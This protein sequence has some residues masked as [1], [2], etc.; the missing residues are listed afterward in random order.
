MRLHRATLRN[1]RIHRQLSVDFN[2]AS[3]LI[4]GPN[5]S[6]KSTL[7][8]AIHRALFLKAKGNTEAHREMVAQG[9]D[10]TPEVQLEFEAGGRRWQLS[11]SFGAAARGRVS[12]SD[13]QGT[14]LA[15]DA[16]EEFLAGL[17]GSPMAGAGK[18]MLTQWAHLWVWQGCSGDDPGQ[19]SQRQHE[20]LI[21]RLQEFGGAGLVQSDSDCRVAT[22]IA[23]RVDTI[24]NRNGT[25]KAGSELAAAERA[26]T[27]ARD[28]RDKARLRW[29]EYG[30]RADDLARRQSEK[31]QAEKDLI[32]LENQRNTVT[33]ALSK[34]EE[35]EDQLKQESIQL[36]RDESARDGLAKTLREFAE[37]QS[38][39]TQTLEGLEPIQR[40]QDQLR[41]RVAE[42]TTEHAQ[43]ESDWNAKRETARRARITLDWL[44]ARLQLARAED[45]F[46]RSQ[47]QLDRLEALERDLAA[48]RQRFAG[49]RPID[50]KGLKRLESLQQAL[51]EAHI[52]LE[53]M[54]A[55]VEWVASDLPVLV[56]GQPLVAGQ[57]RRLTQEGLLQIGTGT[58]L[59]I[60]PGGGGSV[61]EATEARD[62]AA[63]RLRAELDGRGFEDVDT[64]RAAHEEWGVASRAVQ[65]AEQAVQVLDAT[66]VRDTLEVRRSRLLEAQQ[67]VQR[68]EPLVRG[69]EMGP[70]PEGDALQGRIREAREAFTQAEQEEATA[71]AR[72]TSARRRLDQ[73]QD[74]LNTAVEE[75]QRLETARIELEAR[76]TLLRSTHG[77]P[78]DLTNQLQRATTAVEATKVRKAGIQSQV[79]QLNPSALGIRR[80][81]I[82]S[83]LGQLKDRLAT[84]W[85]AILV[86][87]TQL[88]TGMEGGEDPRAAAEQ[89]AAVLRSRE[90]HLEALRLQAEAL[91]RLRD[92]FEEEQRSMASRLVEP[93]QERIR[94]Y[95]GWI[96]G[97]GADVRV[98]LE[99]NGFGGLTLLR[100][101]GFATRFGFDSLSGGTREQVAVAFRLAMAEVLAEDHDGC[102]PIVLDDAFAYSDPDRVK[103]LQDMLFQATKQ[104]LQVIVLTCTPRDY[105]G[106]SGAEILLRRPLPAAP[107]GS[108]HRESS[109][110]LEPREPGD[111]GD[112]VEEGFDAGELA[113]ATGSGAG[114]VQVLPEWCGA[115]LAALP[116][117]GG[118][119]GNGTLQREL[120][121]DDVRYAA[122]RDH[123]LSEAR[124]E[125]GRG[126]GGSVRRVG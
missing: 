14:V 22:E 48:A 46:K 103:A 12:L 58:R 102:L 68:H 64:A 116:S 40:K 85:D 8:E 39:L 28:A 79:D 23:D 111:L 75:S 84:N 27:E 86:L 117:D 123:L 78:V 29:D 49:C 43:A 44:D 16:A 74:E 32:D 87:Q 120:G 88:Q 9:V 45:E 26:V 15:G 73:S 91:R 7:V 100:N 47:A 50:Q 41:S 19:A 5:E 1:Y 65:D 70:V 52:A 31:L 18:D 53:A 96:L 93:F 106:L 98:E 80:E 118:T 71:E 6:G 24:F 72:K 113:S 36:T 11:K 126:R 82:E 66:A 30:Q 81:R 76:L 3:T 112:G 60:R 13:G 67:Q 99:G 61:A 77:D 121:W 97:P 54:A 37:N 95:L 59:R 83:T 69:F 20:A 35:L 63:S 114:V 90:Q 119:V 55:Q 34:V 115:F 105:M 25:P 110:S 2:A 10:A 33:D 108:E 122:V 89:A 62:T 101:E 57:P 107:I 104:G 125:K 109:P 56:D 21:R 38:K 94:R 51:S 17:V 4:G 124:I 42:A 92:L